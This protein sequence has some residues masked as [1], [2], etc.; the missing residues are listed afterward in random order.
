MKL[1][2]VLGLVV[3]TVLI[4]AENARAQRP[5][6]IDV[7]ASQDLVNWTNVKSAGITFAWAKATESTNLT[8]AYFT[9]NAVNAKAA[10]VM[11]GFYHSAHPEDNLGKAG[12]DA[13]A[14]YCWSVISNYVAAD[15][16]TLMPVLDYETVPGDSYTQATS[17]QW[18]NEWCLDMVNFGSSNNVV[19]YPV[20]YTDPSIA[21][22]WLDNTTTQWQLWE[23][24]SNSQDPQTGA[25]TSTSPWTNWT[26]WQ[27]G[28][29]S[30]SGITNG[31]V[32][33]DVFNGVATNL[34]NLVVSGYVDT[35]YYWDPQATNGTN[36]YTNSLAGNWEDNSWSTNSGGQIIP[37]GWF[38]NKAAVIGTHTGLGT[39]SFT[40]TMN[41][42][43]TV[44]GVFNGALIPNACNVTI[45]GPGI[46]TITNDQGFAT[47]NSS[48]GALGVTIISNE[49][50]GTGE[51]VPQQ[52]GQ[53]FL[54]GTNSYTEGTQLGYAHGSF[55]GTINFNNNSSFGT[56][57]IVLSHYGNTG[58]FAV[59]GAS[60]ITIPNSIIV[61]NT[62]TNTFIGNAAGVTYSGKWTMGTSLLTFLTGSASGT[63]DIISGVMSGSGNFTVGG[64]GTL[65]L[66]GANTFTGAMTIN[67]PCLLAIGGS[68]KLN[69]G[70][71]SGNIANGGTFTY[72]SSAG[73][74]LLGIISGFGSLIQNGPGLL[75]LNATNTYLGATIINSGTLALASTGSISGT[76]SISIAPGATF[77]VSATGLS[78]SP[79]TTL[80]ASGAGTNVGT[81]AATIKG[82]SGGTV[83]LGPLVLNYTPQTFAGDATHPSLYLS[84]GALNLTAGGLTVNNTT[85]TPLGAGAYNLIQVAGGSLSAAGTSV[86][87]TGTGLAPNTSG[88]L[89]IT[90]GILNLSVAVTSVSAPRI[91]HVMLSAGSLTLSGTNGP[92]N[93]SYHVLTSTNAAL[94]L[95]MD[96]YRNG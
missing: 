91:N 12:A 17:S 53:L 92:S 23:F 60:A 94:P 49:I 40:I 28:Q 86:S 37:Y 10:G 70:K 38:E 11:I 9:N 31:L 47:F 55:Q 32:N 65:I 71:Y 56:G 73:Q 4:T 36:P 35:L 30:L 18:I 45:T 88:S 59:E 52:N 81:T 48:D 20:V 27:Y 24:S 26:A 51:V 2:P 80:N 78:Y 66:R 1:H 14:A 58:T 57:P 61:S 21:A 50:T 85:A 22:L 72:A 84:Q 42:N 82:S 77:D 90:N 96:Q 93:G 34:T 19:V 69:A 7:S 54:N 95:A 13:E 83:N 25:P 89:S 63:T 44:A 87:V 29:A 41:K 76:A 8:D 79:G 64:F 46:M 3:L 67:A 62:T 16:L 6:G 5:L 68:G 43:H 74:S 39:P 33:E 15:G 75:T